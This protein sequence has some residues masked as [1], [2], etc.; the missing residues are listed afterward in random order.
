MEY[1]QRGLNA[2]NP[3]RWLDLLLLFKS[4]DRPLK[5]GDRARTKKGETTEIGQIKMR[6]R[7]NQKVR[8]GKK[9]S[10]MR[11]QMRTGDN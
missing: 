3:E 7:G 4:G 5:I 8:R 2:E 9:V 10:G 11:G 1:V 6:D